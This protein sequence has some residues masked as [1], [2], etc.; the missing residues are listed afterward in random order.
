[1]K[2]VVALSTVGGGLVVGEPGHPGD[3]EPRVTDGTRGGHGQR[4]SDSG[5]GEA[6]QGRQTGTPDTRTATP[7]P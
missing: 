3:S 5:R 4:Q 6:G 2:Q 1:V 7:Q